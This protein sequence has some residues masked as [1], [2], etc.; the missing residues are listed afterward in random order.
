LF[1]D[2]S[3]IFQWGLFFFSQSFKHFLIFFGG[4][5]TRI[6]N[7]FS[8]V[9]IKNVYY[10]FYLYQ[11]FIGEYLMAILA[12]LTAFFLSLQLCTNTLLASSDDLTGNLGFTEAKQAFVSRKEQVNLN[13][14]VR[15]SHFYRKHAAII[16]SQEYIWCKFLTGEYNINRVCGLAT[17]IHKLVESRQVMLTSPII[18]NNYSFSKF[19]LIELGIL[20]PELPN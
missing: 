7:F 12:Y 4:F 8:D 5:S 13:T 9:L 2:R 17:C 16:V 19:V 6:A 3:K 1:L 18:S 15:Y 14:S 11:I 10:A 20:T